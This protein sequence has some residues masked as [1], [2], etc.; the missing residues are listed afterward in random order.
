MLFI[1]TIYDGAPVYKGDMKT[2]SER[3]GISYKSP[4]DTFNDFHDSI[5]DMV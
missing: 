4:N 5:G 3:L 2:A 1:N